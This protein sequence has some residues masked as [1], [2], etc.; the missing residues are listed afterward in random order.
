MHLRFLPNRFAGI[1]VLASFGAACAVSESGVQA[2]AP[3]ATPVEAMDPEAEVDGDGGLVDAGSKK[4]DAALAP[5][6]AGVKPKD[7]G[8]PLLDASATVDSSVADAG[9]TFLGGSTIAQCQG[10]TAL[11]GSFGATTP[12]VRSGFAIYSGGQNEVYAYSRAVVSDYA[13]GGSAAEFKVRLLL[14]RVTGPGTY[15]GLMGVFRWDTAMAKWTNLAT[16]TDVTTVDIVVAQVVLPG[17]AMCNGRFVGQAQALFSSS[18]PVVFTFDVPLLTPA[19][20]HTMP[21]PP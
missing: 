10:R 7:A 6:D 11:A 8:T 15:Q 2:D 5:K 19:F 18:N 13:Y 21:G 14:P 16:P 1:F 17:T 3:D 9:S 4:A 20:P 12:V